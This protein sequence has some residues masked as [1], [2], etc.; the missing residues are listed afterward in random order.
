MSKTSLS[1]NKRRAVFSATV[2]LPVVQ[3][4]NA[5]AKRFVSCDKSVCS[6]M[7]FGKMKR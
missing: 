7:K 5:N 6:E 4:I 3:L 1:N 2:E